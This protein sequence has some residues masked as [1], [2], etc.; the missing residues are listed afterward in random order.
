MKKE[1]K[2]FKDKEGNKLTSKEFIDKWKVGIENITPLQKTK[3][4]LTG[5]KI[6]LLGLVLGLC[7]TIYGWKNLW[8]VAIILVGAILTTGVQYLATKQQKKLYQDIED[9]FKEATEDEVEISLDGKEGNGMSTMAANIAKHIK[10]DNT[11]GKKD[12][13]SSS[14]NHLDTRSEAGE[15]NKTRDMPVDVEN[16][17]DTL[18]SLFTNMYKKTKFLIKE[19]EVKE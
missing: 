13:D 11:Q 17:P 7:V 1:I 2:I 19:K 3:T 5:T 9:K 18:N 15:D 12:E 8:W 6:T 10:E 14:G 16:H 4:Q